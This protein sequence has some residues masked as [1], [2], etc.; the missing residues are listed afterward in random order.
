MHDHKAIFV[1]NDHLVANDDSAPN[2]NSTS[3]AIIRLLAM[4]NFMAEKTVVE[5]EKR[6][7]LSHA[8]E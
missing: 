4:R 2:D 1:V 7:R 8:H 3:V 5:A 6:Q